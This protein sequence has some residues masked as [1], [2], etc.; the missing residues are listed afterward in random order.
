MRAKHSNMAAGFIKDHIFY[1]STTENICNFTLVVLGVVSAFLLAKSPHV[2]PVY[3]G[4]VAATFATATAVQMG[5]W[6]LHMHGVSGIWCAS[7]GWLIY[8]A[9]IWKKSDK[10][11]FVPVVASLSF[12]TTGFL[13]YVFIGSLETNLGHLFAVG[14]GFLTAHLLQA[15]I[16][17]FTDNDSSLCCMRNLR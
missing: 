14:L 2:R 1:K 15:R 8:F 16:I 9:K 12:L 5:V 13:A 7:L 17:K 3:A 10:L 4:A 6:C 11:S